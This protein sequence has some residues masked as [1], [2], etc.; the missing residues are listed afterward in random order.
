MSQSD[1]QD[2]INNFYKIYQEQ[3]L[4]ELKKMDGERINAKTAVSVSYR[5]IA[6]VAVF[7]IVLQILFCLV[8]K[9][10]FEIINDFS[11]IV[12]FLAFGIGGFISYSTK[13]SFELGLKRKFM[14][15]L[16][17]AFGDMEWSLNPQICNHVIE[18]NKVIKYYESYSTDDNFIGVYKEVPFKIAETELTYE[19]GSGEYRKTV[20]AF[21]GIFILVDIPKKFAGHTIVIDKGDKRET[22]QSPYSEVKLED[23]EFMKK[24]NIYSTDQVEARYVLTPSFMERF[25]NIQKAFGASTI[26]CSFLD[27]ELLVALPCN[28]DL[29]SLG[30]LNISVLSLKSTNTM[31]ELCEYQ[32][33]L[34]ELE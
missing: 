19:T 3:V 11:F 27:N 7:L 23:V 9:H 22:K 33:T 30:D 15:V 31:L 16:M 17:K 18:R 6:I 25:K 2:Y 12:V 10:T 5:I 4:P 8:V 26:S 28:K 14:P 29:F 1:V 20:T 13:K 34:L 21:K 24:F 32:G